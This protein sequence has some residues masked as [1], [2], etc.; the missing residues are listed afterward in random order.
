MTAGADSQQFIIDFLINSNLSQFGKEVGA[1]QTQLKSLQLQQQKAITTNPAA[2]LAGQKVLSAELSKH[3][4]SSGVLNAE[5]PIQRFGNALEKGQLKVRS[6]KEALREY[7]SEAARATSQISRLATEEVRRSQS[8]VVGGRQATPSAIGNATSTSGSRAGQNFTPLKADMSTAIAQNAKLNQE[9]R[10]A[11]VL[12][13]RVNVETVNW[14]KNMQWSGRQIMVGF[15]MPIAVLGGVAAA[16]FIGMNKELTRLQKVYGS[17]TLSGKELADQNKRVAVQGMDLATEMANKYGQ[18]GKETLGLMADIAAAG[19][20][21][22]DLAIA[23]KETTRLMVLGEVDKQKAFE[24]TLSLQNAFKISSQELAGSINFLNAVENQTSLS[25]DDMTTAIPKAGTVVKSLGGNVQDLALFMTALKEGGVGAAEGA[26]AL[27]TGLARIISPT[28]AAKKSLSAFGINLETIVSDNKGNIKNMVFALQDAIA[29]NVP[30]TDKAQVFEKLFGKWQFA[31]MLAMFD[32]LRASGSQTNEVLRLMGASTAELAQIAANEIKTTTES[33]SQRWKIMLESIKMDLS[34]VGKKVVAVLVPIGEFIARVLGGFNKLNP[35]VQTIAL[36]GAGIAA[37]VGPLVMLIGLGANFFGNIKQFVLWT[38]TWA[39]HQRGV[40][41]E[42]NN[43]TDQMRITQELEKL[44]AIE[45]QKTTNSF[46]YMSEAVAKQNG[47]MVERLTLSELQSKLDQKYG[48]SKQKELSIEEQIS[49]KT[50]EVSMLQKQIIMSSREAIA[51]KEQE[52][53]HQKAILAGL[54]AERD[55]LNQIGAARL[56]SGTVGQFNSAQNKTMSLQM[57][58]GGVPSNA[59]FKSVEFEVAGKLKNYALAIDQKTKKIIMA[60]DAEGRTVPI[61]GQLTVAE[62]RLTEALNL[63]AKGEIVAAEA[64]MKRTRMDRLKSGADSN[65][66]KMGIGMTAMMGASMIPDS[67]PGS[68]IIQGAGQGAGLG[69]MIG[70]PY[71]MALGALGGAAFSKISSMQ[72]TIDSDQKKFNA[73]LSTGT[74]A[75]EQFGVK[76]KTAAD[77]GLLSFSTRTKD[78]TTEVAA[79]RN[80]IKQQDDSGVEKALADKIKSGSEKSNADTANQYF[81]KQKSIGVPTEKIKATL[82]AIFQEA[83][84]TMPLEIKT[85]ID[86]KINKKEAAKSLVSKI[87][88]A[89]TTSV[90]GPRVAVGLGG[91]GMDYGPTQVRTLAVDY[92]KLANVLSTIPLNQSVKDWQ[93][94]NREIKDQGINLDSAQVGYD[95]L[96]LT[97]KNLGTTAATD[98]A[99][100]L[101][102]AHDKGYSLSGAMAVLNAGANGLSLNIEDLNAHASDTAYILNAVAV[103][104]NAAADKTKAYNNVISLIRKEVSSSDVKQTQITKKQAEDRS[105]AIE[106]EAKKAQDASDKQIAS[107]ENR[108][109]GQEEAM[110]KNIDAVGKKYD[111]EIAHIQKLED[112]RKKAFEAEQKRI[113]R[114]NELRNMQID[115]LKAVNTGDYFGALTIK[116]NIATKKKDYALQDKDQGET[117][118][119]Q[120][121]IDKLNDKKDR[122]VSRMQDR[123][124]ATKKANEA[125]ISGAKDRAKAEQDSYKKQADASKKAAEQADKSAKKIENAQK[126]LVEKFK[127]H[128]EETGGNITKALEQTKIDAKAH[129][130]NTGR[131]FAKGMKEA[132]KNNLLLFQLPRG[133]T[134][135]S[136]ESIVALGFATANALSQNTAEASNKRRGRAT[137]GQVNGPGTSTSDSVP[138]MASNGE[139]IMS[140]AAVSKHGAGI[141]S[142]INSGRFSLGEIVSRS[143]MSRFSDGGMVYSTQN[144]GYNIGGSSKVAQSSSNGYSVINVHFGRTSASA[145]QIEDVL[146]R[147]VDK[148]NAKVGNR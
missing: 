79:L 107:M 98:L 76:M 141:M 90:E 26:N 125:A 145:K 113:Q 81:L 85:K 94:L 10:I 74:F 60:A 70:G 106:D 19:K 97:L 127:K 54:K 17:V 38:K 136:K 95:A 117:D 9:R 52:L 128:W 109:K 126:W 112:A 55:T 129:G 28:A 35:A 69:M 110:Q 114:A 101:Q 146:Y 31:K 1:V 47:A 27:K 2:L 111:K 72:H 57:L 77:V 62:R 92:G 39:L 43:T 78:A 30:Q 82:D 140:A 134:K 8:L 144:Y 123:L 142:M 83:G 46:R 56:K 61:T 15:T 7:R 65:L 104:S 147:V 14:G 53:I 36:I 148:Q 42:F 20:E 66:G 21:G 68:N 37:L 143:D 25:L 73:T 119:S 100:K 33:A 18:S 75:A 34:K 139:F 13:H 12:Q 133:T 51:Q 99:S 64:T 89:T 138:I 22:N 116:G 23:T 4:Q 40:T 44:V 103:A 130:I 84:R 88:E 32:N 86:F 121:K 105:K 67:V 59:E 132:V 102:E 135:A 71:G 120:N 118:K 93:D 80:A 29:K 115:Y 5:A 3:F 11:E 87:D 124:D 49:K 96:Q 108:F 131:L 50:K 24:T 58:A 6:M 91:G 63:A 45:T 48:N 137:G 41:K 122:V 16:T